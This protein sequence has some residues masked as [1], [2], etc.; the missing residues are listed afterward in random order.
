MVESADS[1]APTLFAI[2]ITCFLI[3]WGWYAL[4]KSSIAALVIMVISGAIVAVYVIFF[5]VLMIA[6]YYMF[7]IMM[8]V[9]IGLFIY[10]VK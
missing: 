10:M 2:S 5:V 6:M 9:I 4:N 8:W 1:W 3:A 7:I